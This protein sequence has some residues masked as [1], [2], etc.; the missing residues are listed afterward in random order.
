MANSKKFFFNNYF[1]FF[2]VEKLADFL[3]ESLATE[4]LG[5][6]NETLEEV[7][8]S[9]LDIHAERYQ[10]GGGKEKDYYPIYEIS[11][12]EVGYCTAVA[13]TIIDGVIISTN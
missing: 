7:K 11:V 1:E 4:G 9:I 12:R 6:T 13:K 8:D 10:G 3:K 5:D 2:T